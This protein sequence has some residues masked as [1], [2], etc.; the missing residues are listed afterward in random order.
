MNIRKKKQNSLARKA[1]FQNCSPPRQLPPEEPHY[2]H[3]PRVQIPQQV[4][5]TFQPVQTVVAPVLISNDKNVILTTVIKFIS[6]KQYNKYTSFYL[7]TMYHKIYI[8]KIMTNDVLINFIDALTNI[9]FIKYYTY[10]TTERRYLQVFPKM[11][12]SRMRLKR[13]L[14][15]SLVVWEDCYSHRYSPALLPEEGR[16][17][18]RG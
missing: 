3:Q 18:R 13:S 1:D 5:Q 2:P 4:A 17:R 7:I 6:S 14:G 11:E 10:N 12:L 9:R 8:V 16:R 15:V